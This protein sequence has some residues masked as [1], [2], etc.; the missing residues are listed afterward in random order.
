VGLLVAV[1]D[2]T[3]TVKVTSARRCT[4]FPPEYSTAVVHGL[5]RYTTY[6]RSIGTSGFFANVHDG[7]VTSFGLEPTFD[8][9]VGEAAA[10]HMRFDHIGVG[11]VERGSLIWARVTALAVSGG[12][13]LSGLSLLGALQLKAHGN[14][15]VSS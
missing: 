9:I 8:P 2:G 7:T 10:G 3:G 11:A 14:R 5:R 12:L 13:V 6:S 15:H 4:M 1:Q